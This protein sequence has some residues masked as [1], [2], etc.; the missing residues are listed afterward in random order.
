MVEI[1]NALTKRGLQ[2]TILIDPIHVCL[3]FFEE[4]ICQGL[5]NKHVI[6]SDAELT[7]VY[8]SQGCR[9]LGRIVHVAGLVND[10]RALA[11]QLEDA[12]D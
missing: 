11:A 5:M 4:G 12:R 6:A 2:S 10:K 3:E 7:T 8:E 9:F 1:I